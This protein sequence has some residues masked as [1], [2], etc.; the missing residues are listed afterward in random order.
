MAFTL[1]IGSKAIGFN[2]PATDGQHYSL[3]SFKDFF[4]ML[5]LIIVLSKK[6]VKTSGTGV[7]TAISINRVNLQLVQ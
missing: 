5:F 3:D 6:G 1:E 7:I 2:L 4:T